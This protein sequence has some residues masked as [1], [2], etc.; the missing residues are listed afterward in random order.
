MLCAGVL[1]DGSDAIGGVDPGGAMRHGRA[2]RR[3]QVPAERVRVHR[4][5][6][7]GA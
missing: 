5:T 6:G 1:H 2:A 3:R 7:T 4:Q